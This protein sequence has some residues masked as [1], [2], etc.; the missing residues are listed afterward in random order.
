[1]QKKGIWGHCCPKLG[2]EFLTL[3]ISQYK[4]IK[5]YSYYTTKIVILKTLLLMEKTRD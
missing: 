1:M 4:I 2:E 3:L 5:A